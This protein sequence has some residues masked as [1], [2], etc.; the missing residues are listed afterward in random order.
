[1]PLKGF[2]DILPKE[3]FYKLPW[4]YGFKIHREVN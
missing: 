2:N 1:V 3:Q 4:G